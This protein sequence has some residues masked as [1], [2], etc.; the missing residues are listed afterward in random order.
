MQ[1]VSIKK[2][3][4]TASFSVAIDSEEPAVNATLFEYLK[5]EFDLDIRGLDGAIEGLKASEIFAMIRMEIAKQKGWAV[6]EDSYL[7][8]FSFARYQ[9]WQDIRKNID[10]F[11][12]NPLIAS[13]LQNRSLIDDRLELEQNE[14]ESKPSQTLLPL[15]ADSSQ[16]EA[17]A[18]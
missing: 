10:E 15:P 9:M 3:K 11:A 17:I 6:Y 12:K 5:Q 4:G 14:D 7:A 13:L 18:L 16:W 1:P 2:R 8:A